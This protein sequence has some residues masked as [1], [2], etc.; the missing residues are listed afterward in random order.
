MTEKSD[1]AQ[2]FLAEIDDG[3]RVFCVEWEQRV[4][5]CVAATSQEEA[6][7]AA[8][9]I[10]T[11]DL[12]FDDPDISVSPDLTVQAEGMAKRLKTPVKPP[13]PDSGVW[14]GD[15][16][17]VDEYVAQRAWKMIGDAAGETMRCAKCGHEDWTSEFNLNTNPPKYGYVPTMGC[18]ECRTPIDWM[19][20][21][22]S[23]QPEKED[24]E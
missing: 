10:S 8:E 20:L 3:L 19:Q 23:K 12:E 7:E 1:A 4:S 2:K 15:I 17:H 13:Q 11:M 9:N 21:V 24:G 16:V 18:P 6:K 14:E 5:W 22:K